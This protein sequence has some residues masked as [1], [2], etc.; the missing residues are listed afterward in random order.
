[1]NRAIWSYQQVSKHIR[2]NGCIRID[3][4]DDISHF[5][6]LSK[7]A[8]ESLCVQSWNMVILNKLGLV[9]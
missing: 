8:D 4:D 1:M 5:T 2:T 9:N 3:D 6:G 7:T